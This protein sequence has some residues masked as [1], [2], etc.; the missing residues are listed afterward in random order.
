[1]TEI[2]GL[3]PRQLTTSGL[4]LMSS[5]AAHLSKYDSGEIKVIFV[6]R[7][8]WPLPSTA[9]ASRQLDLLQHKAFLSNSSQFAFRINKSSLLPRGC[10]S[11]SWTRFLLFVI[12]EECSKSRRRQADGIN[13]TDSRAL[14]SFHPG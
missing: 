3:S 12:G 9:P 2:S 4:L 5:A 11:A 8:R 7:A 1:M 13:N 14:Y 6:K 10:I